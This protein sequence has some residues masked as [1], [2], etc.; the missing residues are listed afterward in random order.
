MNRVG[1]YYYY[2]TTLGRA[3]GKFQIPK[4]TCGL[5]LWGTRGV[6]ISYRK[7]VKLVSWEGKITWFMRIVDE[8]FYYMY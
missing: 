2:T 4:I 8:N 1:G 3:A 6:I 5:W 7:G